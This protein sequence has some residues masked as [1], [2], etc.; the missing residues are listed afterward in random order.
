[1]KSNIDLTNTKYSNIA[2]NMKMEMFLDL[3]AKIF[4]KLKES[5]LIKLLLTFWDKPIYYQES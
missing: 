2:P 4:I 1:M 5:N 3:L